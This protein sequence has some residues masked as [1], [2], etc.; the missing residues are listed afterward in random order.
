VRDDAVKLLAVLGVQAGEYEKFGLF[1]KTV[2]DGVRGLSV[3]LFP[4]DDGLGLVM[5]EISSALLRYN[6]AFSRISCFF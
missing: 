4:L 2:G 3:A 6:F 1:T 5:L